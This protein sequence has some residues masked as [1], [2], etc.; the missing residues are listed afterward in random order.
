MKIEKMKDILKIAHQSQNAVHMIGPH[1]IGKTEIVKQFAEEEGFWCETLQLTVMDESDLMGMPVIS[2]DHRGDKVTT[3]AKPVW[4]QRIQK[5]NE[6]GKHVIV[7]MDELGRASLSIRQ[8]SLQMV[9]EG[10]IQEHSLGFLDDLNT[11]TIV[12]DN[13]SDEYDSS[14]FD[15]ALEDR[16]I[17]LDVEASIEGFLKYA[18]E[19]ELNPV[20]TDFLAEYPERLVYNPEDDTEKGSS[21]RAWES[22]SRILKVTPKD[23]PL[24]NTLI[25]SKVGKTV[26]A[27][28]F[29]YLRNYINVISVE[30]IINTIGDSK[31]DT[32]DQQKKMA[33]KLSK[34]TKKMEVI[35]ATE[36][37]EK[38]LKEHLSENSAV[39][40]KEVAVYVV[41]LNIEVAAGIL[42][43][44]KD[45]DK[46]EIEAFYYD[47]FKEATPDHWFLSELMAWHKDS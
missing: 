20:I 12:A 34:I 14:D 30:D 25:L 13:P 47:G 2:E 35:S 43:T 6:D 45:S 26:G 39:S 15:A 29:H 32:K 31:I 24:L 4:L 21:P 1:G 36:L 9:L 41:S 16:F 23:S 44:W 27:S 7:F 42:K 5:A 38:M 33:K 3:W 22:L 28:F 37:A 40:A 8:A 11:L 46:K 17:T 10:K 19:K 18:R